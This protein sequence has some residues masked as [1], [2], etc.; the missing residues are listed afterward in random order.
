MKKLA[1]Y[2]LLCALALVCVFPFWW[3]LVTA[4]STEGNIFAFPPTFWPREPSLE[5]FIAVF[6][7]LP[8]ATFL[9]NSLLI[10]ACTVFW[11]LALCSRKCRKT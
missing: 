1:H 3:T 9:G 6:D 11:K 7:A 5:N 2:L 10:A 8:V 4:L